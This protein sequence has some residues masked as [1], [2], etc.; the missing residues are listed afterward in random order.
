MPLFPDA[1]QPLLLSDVVGDES[2]LLFSPAK[3]WTRRDIVLFSL[4]SAG[5]IGFSITWAYLFVLPL[6]G[7]L[8]HCECVWIWDK[9]AG[10]LAAP[11]ADNCPFCGSGKL[12]AASFVPQWGVVPLM[13]A[14]ALLMR[15]KK[16]QMYIMRLFVVIVVF[17]GFVFAAALI[18]ELASGYPHFL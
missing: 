10:C 3:G 2:S 6:C 4:E 13:L 16:P 1:T 15:Y 7:G 14:A 8:F 5:W 18:F 17:F 12:D 11:R 9:S